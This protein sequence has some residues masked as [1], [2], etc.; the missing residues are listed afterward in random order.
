MD[1]GPPP[2]LGGA[3]DLAL[4]QSVVELI[5]ASAALDP[6]SGQLLDI[7][8]AVVGNNSLGTDDGSGYAFNP[9]TGQPYPPNVVRLGDFGRVMAEFWAD[10]PASTTPPGHWNEIANAVVDHPDFERRMTGAGPELDR[11][12]WDV[13]L[14][15]ALNGAL[16]DSAIV[17][18]GSQTQS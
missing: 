10:G 17:T 14:Y 6:D 13:K 4:K 8:P 7:S 9:V 2:R 11:L 3:G 12:E 18:L 16:H 1:P 5:R 15:L